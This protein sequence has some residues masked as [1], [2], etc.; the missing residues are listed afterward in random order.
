[1]RVALYEY[2][3]DK[4]NAITQDHINRD[5]YNIKP[6]VGDSPLVI[7]INKLNIIMLVMAETK[8]LYSK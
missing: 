2:A 6:A 7:G 4:L 8:R 1:M 3:I 5:Q